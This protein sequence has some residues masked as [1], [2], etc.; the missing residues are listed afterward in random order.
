MS[1]ICYFGL[2]RDESRCS[3][4]ENTV[5]PHAALNFTAMVSVICG[6]FERL[7]QNRPIGDVS[8]Q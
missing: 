3:F 2:D 5:D 6:H 8:S 1:D 4:P 7:A